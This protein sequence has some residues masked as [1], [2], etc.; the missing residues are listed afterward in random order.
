MLALARFG[1]IDA[2][3]ERMTATFEHIERRLAVGPLLYRY[4]PGTDDLPGREGAFG[5]AGFWAVDYLAR[6][7]RIDEAER[8]FAALVA[9]A[10]DVGLFA[11]EIDPQSGAQLGN[12]PQGYTH[13]GLITAAVSLHA[14]K[15]HA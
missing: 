4:V 5:I 3:D 14:A 2:R 8:R 9:H 7:G 12:F 10:N 6:A 15:G 11:E 1:F 13:V